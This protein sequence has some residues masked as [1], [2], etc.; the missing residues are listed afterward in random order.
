MSAVRSE[1]VVLPPKR[2]DGPVRVVARQPGHPVRLQPGADD[3]AVRLDRAED[4]EAL[5]GHTQAVAAQQVRPSR[6]REM[7]QLPLRRRAVP[8]REQIADVRARRLDVTTATLREEIL[9]GDLDSFRVVVES[10][11]D[12]FD[13]MDVA[14]AGCRKIFS[15]S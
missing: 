8:I 5:R 10:L 7:L 14:A 11:A 3:D 1:P 6:F 15:V 13:V 9:E 4:G 2:H 12:E